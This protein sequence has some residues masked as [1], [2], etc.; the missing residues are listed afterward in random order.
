MAR[1]DVVL[2]LIVTKAQKTMYKVAAQKAGLSMSMW[3]RVQLN[4]QALKE[5][6]RGVKQPK[7]IGSDRATES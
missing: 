4:I 2:S 6:Q 3:I 5:L 7:L 1:D